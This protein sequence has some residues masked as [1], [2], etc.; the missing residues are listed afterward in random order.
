MHQLYCKSSLCMEE[1]DDNSVHLV[2]TSPPYNVGQEYETGVSNHTWM[3]MLRNVFYECYRVLVPGGRCCINIANVGRSPYQNP[4]SKIE[5]MCRVIFQGM[6]RGEIIW[7]KGK[8]NSSS[9]AWGTWKSPQNP[10]L[11]DL[12]EYIMI[13]S[14]GQWDRPDK[15]VSTVSKEGFLLYTQ[16]VWTIQPENSKKIKHPCPFPVE[17]PRRLIELYSYLGDTVL[18]P[19]MGSGTTGVAA[20]MTGRK[21]IGYD[22]IP[23]YVEEADK[24]IKGVEFDRATEGSKGMGCTDGT[25]TL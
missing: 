19:F 13:F 3:V 1:V 23:E 5:L 25:C 17:M 4:R 10:S 11:R 24:R 18:D 20:K 21:F 8:A 7:I 16:S 12:H 14:K 9:T 6:H 2:I 15:G 22:I